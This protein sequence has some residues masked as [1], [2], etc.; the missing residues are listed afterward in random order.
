MSQTIT[1][2]FFHDSVCSWCYLLSP[3][4]KI[5][6]DEIPL[7]IRHHTFT[8]SATKEEMI[9]HFGSAAIAKET[10]LSHWQQVTEYDSSLLINVEGM[11]KQ[12]FDYPHGGPAA[13][14]CKAAE[15]QEGSSGHW[16][17]FDR[18]Q[19]AHF[20]ENRNI[21]DVN[22]LLELANELGLDRE[23]FTQDLYKQDTLD[24]VESDQFLA[25][26]WGIRSVPS[27]VVEQRWIVPGTTDLEHLKAMLLE[28]KTSLSF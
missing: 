17:Y 1:I 13:L 14:A 2:D 21:A 3:Q 24:K 12:T 7:D 23:R 19:K 9:S 18:V 6:A 28:A 22:V 15:V 11:R 10:I 5:L 8:L 20:H 16:R 27:L 25:K 26:K 4:L